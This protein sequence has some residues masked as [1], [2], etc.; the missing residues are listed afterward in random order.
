VEGH[1][2]PDRHPEIAG[3]TQQ[4]ARQQAKDPS[5]EQSDPIVVRVAVMRV[6]DEGR[7]D[8]RGWPEAYDRGECKQRIYTSAKFFTNGNENENECQYNG[9][10]KTILSVQ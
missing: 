10:F 9:H 4:E 8:N 7:G 3:A 2:K 5:V 6:A 1:L